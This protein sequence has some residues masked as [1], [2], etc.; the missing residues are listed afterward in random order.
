MRTHPGA[1]ETGQEKAERAIRHP[2][3][4]RPLHDEHCT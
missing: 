4:S 3:I 2:Q 1:S